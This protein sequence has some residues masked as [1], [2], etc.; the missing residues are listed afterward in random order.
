MWRETAIALRCPNARTQRWASV[1]AEGCKDKFATG[2]VHLRIGSSKP[3]LDASF[4]YAI[5][6]FGARSLARSHPTRRL[7]SKNT[8][9][10]VFRGLTTIEKT[11]MRSPAQVFS[12]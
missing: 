7:P 6:R 11:Q 12:R 2:G 5:P 1:A 9:N 4:T 10:L 3:R 8:T